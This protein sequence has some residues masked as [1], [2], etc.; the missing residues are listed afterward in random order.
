MR[1][2]CCVSCCA[3]ASPLGLVVAIGVMSYQLDPTVAAK[4]VATRVQPAAPPP[5]AAPL[6]SAPELTD[7]EREVLRLVSTGATNREIADKLFIG[8]AT[9][10][11]ISP[12]F[13]DALDSA[14]AHRRPSTRA[15]TASLEQLD[16]LD[17]GTSTGVPGAVRGRPAPALIASR[18]RSPPSA[19]PA[20]STSSA[21]AGPCSSSASC[22]SDP[23]ALPSSATVCTMPAPTS[24][25][26][27]SA[28]SSWPA[29][30]AVAS[31]GRRPAPWSTS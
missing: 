17:R 1:I 4:L 29:S 2:D 31:L 11:S 23:S 21:S 20:P 16:D 8:E 18:F 25:R 22:S 12:T 28:S 15:T 6:P 3:I 5:A 14:T 10:K 26:S 9:V 13:W 19:S 27:A 24:F 7:R 30:F